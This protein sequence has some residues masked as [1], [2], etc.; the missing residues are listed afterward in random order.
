MKD[1]SVPW[2]GAYKSLWARRA[3]SSIIWNAARLKLERACASPCWTKPMKCWTWASARISKLILEQTPGGL[4]DGSCSPPRCR[5]SHSASWA[6][7]SCANP[8]TADASPHKDAHGPRHRAGC[9]TRSVHTRR[10]TRCAACW[11]RRGSARLW[12]SAAT[13]RGVDESD[14][15][16]AAARLSGGRAAR[17]PCTRPQRDRRDER[18]SAAARID[19][20]GG[21]GRGRARVST[22]T[23]WMR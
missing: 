5:R 17:R 8:E 11:T 9:T 3:E 19:D 21:D 12:C 14:G 7:V 23:M 20:A 16:P 2:P 6:S 13:K 15:P 4:P 1:S 22:W 18:A 10:W